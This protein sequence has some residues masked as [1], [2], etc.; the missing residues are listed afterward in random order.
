MH[1]ATR[2]QIPRISCYTKLMIVIKVFSKDLVSVRTARVIHSKKK[3]HPCR[4]SKAIRSRKIVIL[5]NGS[6]CPFEKIVIRSNGSSYPF[7]TIVS[8]AT[9]PNHFFHPSRLL[10]TCQ[11]C[12]LIINNSS[13]R[14]LP[15]PHEFSRY[16]FCWIA[17]FTFIIFDY[18]YKCY[19]RLRYNIQQVS[20]TS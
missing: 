3:C 4:T 5:S 13:K 12:K 10:R 18:R 6:G 14:C 20:R 7:K 1:C 11:K 17:F 16:I 19:L 2:T 8:R 15:S 9:V